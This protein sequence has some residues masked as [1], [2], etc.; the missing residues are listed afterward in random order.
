MLNTHEKEIKEIIASRPGQRLLACILLLQPVTAEELRL[1]PNL[2]LRL[3]NSF[4]P[5]KHK[6]LSD[7]AKP[8]KSNLFPQFKCIFDNKEFSGKNRTL[9]KAVKSGLIIKKPAKKGWKIKNYYFLNSDI[10]F[11]INRN[12]IQINENK[13]IFRKIFT[14]HIR[15]YK[16]SKKTIVRERLNFRR[17]SVLNPSD[18]ITEPLLTLNQI[19]RL[20]W[21]LTKHHSLISET[22]EVYDNAIYGSEEKPKYKPIKVKDLPPQWRK[23]RYLFDKAQ[24]E[25]VI[26]MGNDN[27]VWLGQFFDSLIR[28]KFFL[29]FVPTYSILKC[30]S[31]VGNQKKTSAE[32]FSGEKKTSMELLDILTSEDYVI[33]PGKRPIVFTSLLMYED[34]DKDKLRIPSDISEES[35]KSI[36]K[37]YNSKSITWIARNTQL[38]ENIMLSPNGSMFPFLMNTHEK[39]KVYSRRHPYIIPAKYG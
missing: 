1:F 21:W 13:T 4:S 29:Y 6:F 38:A 19:F 15:N 24:R 37:S 17:P 2:C 9:K 8:T 16:S 20:F 23:N 18:M 31:Y 35:Y 14:H 10:S 7:V 30:F 27:N 33:D 26:I 3:F 39:T 11:E 12:G 22:I 36:M 34:F 5:D 32:F 28:K 25:Q